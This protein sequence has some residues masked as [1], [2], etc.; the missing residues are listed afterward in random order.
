MATGF[1][2]VSGNARSAEP[3][4]TAGKRPEW[5]A[6]CG[7]SS[8]RD[9]ACGA[10][11]IK[12]LSF[13]KSQIIYDQHRNNNNGK[14]RCKSLNSNQWKSTTI[15]VPMA[16]TRMN[17]LQDDTSDEANDIVKRDSHGFDKH[18][19]KAEPS[20]PKRSRRQHGS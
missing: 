14:I 1:R 9:I 2:R 15:R 13:R 11:H 19:S 18:S 20:K 10:R 4:L 6:A 3:C 17:W 12:Q 8:P 7:E 5:R 16:H